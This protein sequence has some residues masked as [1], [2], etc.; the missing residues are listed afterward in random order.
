MSDKDRVERRL[1]NRAE[2]IQ[3]ILSSAFEDP[4]EIKSLS[5][6]VQ[7]EVILSKSFEFRGL[8]YGLESLFVPRGYSVAIAIIGDDKKFALAYGFGKAKDSSPESLLQADKDALADALRKAQSLLN[9]ISISSGADSESESER[10]EMSDTHERTS[11]TSYLSAEDRSYAKTSKD[12]E[13][14]TLERR[15]FE[16]EISKSYERIEG[17]ELDEEISEPKREIRSK[18]YYSKGMK[19]NTYQRRFFS[20]VAKL[21][22]SL[23]KAKSF[24]KKHTGKESTKDVEPE[25]WN[26]VLALLEE[27]LKL[28][29]REEVEEDEWEELFK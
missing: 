3:L 4:S 23:D 26:K 21:N 24:L 12:P 9:G 18:P 29:S 2:V 17:S 16:K 15:S 22:W 10:G 19:V 6:D 7:K 11:E 28:A 5:P 13:E 8:R 27:Q 1:K 14:K 25:E 20:L